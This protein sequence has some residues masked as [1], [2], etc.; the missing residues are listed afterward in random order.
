[1]NL[2]VILCIGSTGVVGDSLG[3]MVGDLLRDKY[4]IPAYVYGGFRAPVNGVNF[5]DY[6]DHI[7]KTHPFSPVIAVDACV[8]APEDVGKIKFARGGIK[9]GG[10]LD[11]DLRPVGDI[12]VLGVVTARSKDNLTALMSVS[13]S[14]VE[15]LSEKIAFKIYSVLSD[16]HAFNYPRSLIAL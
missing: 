6:A 1:M 10:A 16:K 4:D 5:S 15:T 12:G 7:S 9:A 8:G 3:P 11:K 13:Y 14:L 2:P